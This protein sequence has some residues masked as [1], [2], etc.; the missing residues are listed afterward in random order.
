MGEATPKV[1]L[2]LE[3]GMS[4]TDT[5]SAFC[6]KYGVGD[7]DRSTLESA[8]KKR[9][10][11]PPPLVLMLGVVVP[12]GHRRIL[13]VPEGANMTLETHVFCAKYGVTRED[14]CDAILTRV[15]SLVNV[16]YLRRVVLTVPINAPDGRTLQL[17]IREGEQHDL[18]QY[19]SDFFELYNMP[20]DTIG[21]M[22][23]EVNKRS[24]IPH[25][26]NT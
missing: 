19:V 1:N 18:W 16:D 24:G 3:E 9:V 2:T 4:L 6:R 22:V 10:K 8:L 25:E 5:V 7:A 23:A 26:Y 11:S 17:I 21:G 14:Q 20:R 15:T 12:T 13:A